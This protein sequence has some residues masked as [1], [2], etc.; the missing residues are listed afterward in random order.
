MSHMCCSS[1]SH[2]RVYVTHTRIGIVE[3]RI[4]ASIT[5]HNV[6]LILVAADMHSAHQLKRV[7]SL[8]LSLSLA[9]SRSL[10]LARSRSLSLARSRSL[11]LSLARLRLKRVSLSL[12]HSLARSLSLCTHTPT[13]TRIAHPCCAL[14]TSIQRGS[15]SV[16]LSPHT[17]VSLILVGTL[18]I[19]S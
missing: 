12:A 6:S 18:H 16:S 19:I 10:S 14:S 11:S 13:Q 7:I 4:M 3:Q 15:L 17:Q 2:I 5:V 9:R 1:F 8:S